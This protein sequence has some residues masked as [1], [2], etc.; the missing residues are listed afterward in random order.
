MPEILT[1]WLVE[2]AVDGHSIRVVFFSYAEVVSFLEETRGF[3]A[4]RPVM[5]TVLY[6]APRPSN[7]PSHDR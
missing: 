6:D 7:H 1:G 4:V 3:P 5:L 2:H